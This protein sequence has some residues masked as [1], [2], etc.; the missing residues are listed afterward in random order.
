M[1]P[2]FQRSSSSAPRATKE[3]EIDQSVRKSRKE[4][5][6]SFW[7]NCFSRTR[8]S[9]VVEPGDLLAATV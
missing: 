4:R 5:H 9:G 1:K 8:Q 3:G 7:V 6:F 2:E